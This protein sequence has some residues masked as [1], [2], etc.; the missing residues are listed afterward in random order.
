MKRALS[1]FLLTAAASFAADDVV[2]RAMRDEL[3]R[4][5]KKLQLESLQK[6]YFIA[7][8]SPRCRVSQVPRLIFPGALSPT[9]PEG[10]TSACSLLPADCRLHLLWQTGHLH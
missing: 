4:S 10:P 5:M 6:P 3:A 9:T 8:P 7:Y 1:A 2:M